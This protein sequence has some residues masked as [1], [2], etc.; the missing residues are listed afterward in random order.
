MHFWKKKKIKQILMNR[1][2]FEM[3]TD[4]QKAA[5]IVSNNNI[6]NEKSISEMK[7]S[8]KENLLK[9]N[10][11]FPNLNLEQALSS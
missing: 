11:H 3:E 5:L 6:H 1:L 9:L 4:E 7:I 8:V 2:I 10:L